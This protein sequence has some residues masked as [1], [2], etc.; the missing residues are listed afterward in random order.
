MTGSIDKKKVDEAGGGLS[1]G[2]SGDAAAAAP[3]AETRPGNG[4][5]DDNHVHT[6]PP[7]LANNSPPGQ[8]KK[9]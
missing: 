9:N 5:G 4:F 6:G 8:A 3:S 1:G 2:L 7:G